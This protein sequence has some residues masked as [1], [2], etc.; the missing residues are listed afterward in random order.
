MGNNSNNI[1]NTIKLDD[2][3]VYTVKRLEIRKSIVELISI[4]S[5][6]NNIFSLIHMAFYNGKG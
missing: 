2:T 4:I 1:I 3:K 6:F 5:S